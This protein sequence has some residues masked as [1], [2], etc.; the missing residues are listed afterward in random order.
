MTE[1]KDGCVNKAEN[2][3]IMTVID[4]EEIQNSNAKQLSK[5]KSTET[6]K[7]IVD[8]VRRAF[9]MG[10]TKSLKF[11]EKQLKNL[12]RLFTE[13]ED[14]L[15]TALAKDLRK[16]KFE[17][18]NYEIEITKNEIR[19]VLMN[20][21]SWAKPSRPEKALKQFFDGLYIYKDPLGVVLVI[22]PWNYPVQLTLLP[23]AGAIAAGNCIVLKPSDISVNVTALLSKLVPRYLDKECFKVFE[24]GVEETK[25]LLKERF[26]YIFFT[27]STAVGKIVHQAAAKYLTP[28]TLELGGKSPVYIDTSADVNIASKRIMWGKVMNVG[29]TCIAPDYVL[30]SREVEKEFISYAKKHLLDFFGTNVKKS[31]DY[32]R[33]VSDKH[34]KRLTDFLKSNK[35]VIGGDYD[36]K[37]R[38]IEPTVLA[39]V[40]PNDPIMQ[41]EIFGPILPI[42]NVESAYEA[43]SFIRAREKPLALYIFSKDK[44]ITEYLLRSTTSGGVTVNDTLMHIVCEEL[45]FGG[46]GM[47][48]MGSYHGKKSFDVFVHEKSVLKKCMR[49]LVEQMNFMRYPPYTDTKL[50]MLKMYL[51]KRWGLSRETW[52]RI[53]IFIL[54]AVFAFLIQF[55]F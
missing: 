22:G 17:S 6:P 9:E 12:M 31:P 2:V 41:E 15:V 28:T 45:P 29:Q 33:I 10:K 36:P 11:R 30:C 23:L 48:G 39:N 55:L 49:P 26:D 32:G 38:Y 7:E 40:S 52:Q 27:G 24:G 25:E 1:E 18:C 14:A 34:F 46:V 35:V 50:K 5:T 16:S 47:S 37:D 42:V 54:G 51:K 21:K 13:N 43:V 19:N 20:F 8:S 44:K 53:V 4:V 3:D